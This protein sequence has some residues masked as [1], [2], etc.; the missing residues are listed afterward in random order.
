MADQTFVII[1]CKGDGMGGILMKQ[2]SVNR[3]T[4]IIEQVN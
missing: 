3:K 4:Y 2:I 1:T